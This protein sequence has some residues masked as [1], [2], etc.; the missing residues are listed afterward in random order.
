MDWREGYQRMIVSAE[1]AV[2]VIQSGNRVFLQG[3]CGV[4]QWLEAALVARAG[5]L[6]NVEIIHIHSGGKAEYCHPQ[7]QSSFRH[8]A[9]FM[10]DNTRDAIN[11]GCADF[12][13]AWLSDM[14][15]LMRDGH[16]PVDV[17]LIHLT[18]PDTHGYCSFGV[19]VDVAK[20]ASE[21]ARVVV[22]QVNDQMPRTLG[23]SFI[24]VGKL[25][26]IVPVSEPI[27]YHA[28]PRGT[29]LQRRI[30]YGVAELIEDGSTL[31]MG[32]GG[33]PD[34]I[35][36]HLG[37]RRDLGVHTELLQEG[38]MELVEEGVIT[39]AR[40]TIDRG[41]AVAAFMMGT[42]RLYDWVDNNPMVSMQPTDYTNNPFIISRN[43]KMIAINSAIQIDLTGQVCSDSIGY[44]FYSGAGGQA[45]FM[46]GASHSKGGKCILAMPSTASGG[47]ISRIVPALAEGAGVVTTRYQVQYVATE[48]GVVDLKGKTI[49]QRAQ[50]LISIAHPDFREQLSR[51][52]RDRYHIV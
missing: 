2:R 16:L 18:M 10:S 26:Y 4:P 21:S 28:L 47:R 34:A 36:R 35:L 48:Y 23:D 43:D 41:K 13:P 46:I 24:H 31:Q 1:E 14:A 44:D 22:A 33:I 8:N 32:I 6:E 3:G 27:I 39:N 19:S 42:Q 25:D 37:D 50:A 40:K 20:P 30:A 38:V 49:R 52:A 17:A 9:L 7:Y 51:I 29:E 11:S 15:N 5:E 12:T 45:D